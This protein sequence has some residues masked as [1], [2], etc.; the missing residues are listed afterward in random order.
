MKIGVA[1]TRLTPPWDVPLGGTGQ[2]WSRVRDHLAATALVLADP[3]GNI[4]VAI[5]SVDLYTADMSLLT[6]VRQGLAPLPMRMPIYLGLSGSPRTPAWAS[7]PHYAQFVARQVATAIV[8]ASRS[9][10]EGSLAVGA[11]DVPGWTQHRD[12]PSRPVD[13]HLVVW[14]LEDMGRRPLAVV[15]SF[16]GPANVQQVLAPDE[17]SRDFPGQVTDLLERELPGVTGLFLPAAA[18]D[19]V[20][21]PEC[22]SVDRCHTPGVAIAQRALQC[23]RQARPICLTEATQSDLQ[24]AVR[25]AWPE[26]LL[27]EVSEQTSEKIRGRRNQ[28][29]EAMLL[30]RGL[31]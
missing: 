27:E 6:A 31:S 8:Q 4:L 5:V 19:S 23:W 7:D 13:Q 30:V 17:I 28:Q 16:A 18:Q 10:R 12:D 26:T 24:S 22:Y 9:L 2:P 3:Q 14:R 25:I 21:R 20:F 11:A 1:R 29:A 15:L